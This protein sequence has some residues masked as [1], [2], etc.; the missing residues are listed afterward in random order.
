MGFGLLFP[1]PTAISNAG[2]RA[3]R[4]TEM[5]IVNANY[6]SARWLRSTDLLSGETG[7]V[8]TR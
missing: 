5:A 3:S 6:M 2:G 4:A 8:G 1:S 7:R